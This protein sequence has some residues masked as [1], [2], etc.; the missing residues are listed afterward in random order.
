MCA[1]CCRSS[2]AL[3][4]GRGRLPRFR[5]GRGY[6]SARILRE[7]GYAGEIEATGDVLV[8]QL[9]SCAAAASTA[10]RPKCRSNP[11][12]VEAALNRYPRSLSARRRRRV[13]D[14]GASGMAE[15]RVRAID[16]IDTGPRFTEAD[17]DRAQP[18]ASAATDTVEMLASCCRHAGRRSRGGL[19]LRRRK[20]GAAASRRAGRS[21]DAGDVPRNRQDFPET[22]DYRDLLIE[23]LGL[24]D[25]PST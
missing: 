5:D 19:Q 21:D 2:T 9:S 17:A 16:R 7:A 15:T 10:S 4:A 11:A 1:S 13:A 25:C 22:L 24:T 3:R 20:R 12:D 18:P 6:S 8:D 23:R 14:L